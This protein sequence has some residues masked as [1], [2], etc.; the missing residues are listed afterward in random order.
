MESVFT[1]TETFRY[2]LDATLKEEESTLAAVSSALLI[3]NI[4][5]FSESATG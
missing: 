1:Q 4:L 5:L 2:W 3:M